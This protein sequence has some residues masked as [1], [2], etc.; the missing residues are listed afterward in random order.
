MYK[1]WFLLPMGWWW[2]RWGSDGWYLYQGFELYQ[3]PSGVLKVTLSNLTLIGDSL[4]WQDSGL[5]SQ[6]ALIFQLT[7]H[8][9]PAY[10]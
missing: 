8:L 4:T 7:R 5:P 10:A 2:R 1:L 3:I 9:N 6:F